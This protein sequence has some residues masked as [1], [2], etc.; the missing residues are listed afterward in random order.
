M[1]IGLGCRDQVAAMHRIGKLN[2]DVGLGWCCA[3]ELGP[4]QAQ[5][6]DGRVRVMVRVRVGLSPVVGTYGWVKIG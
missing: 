1:G 5:G 3:C 6:Q 4:C 2:G